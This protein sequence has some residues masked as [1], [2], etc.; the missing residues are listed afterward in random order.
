MTR[1]FFTNKY[2]KV[3]MF[4]VPLFKTI[5]DAC[6]GKPHLYTYC[7][8]L[9]NETFTVDIGINDE[10]DMNYCE[11]I[12][13]NNQKEWEIIVKECINFLYDFEYAN[14]DSV[15]NFYVKYLKP[16]INTLK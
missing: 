10:D 13:C 4:I 14:F 8:I 11:S 15:Y 16:F 12:I 5:P 3:Y 1:K 7:R 9:E 2:E 6:C